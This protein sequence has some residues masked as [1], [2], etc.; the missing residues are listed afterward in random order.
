M[1]QYIDTRLDQNSL[2]LILIKNKNIAQKHFELI[3]DPESYES[4]FALTCK[5]I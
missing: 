5:D 3:L 4:E 2:N 1:L